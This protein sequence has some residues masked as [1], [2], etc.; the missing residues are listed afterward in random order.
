MKMIEKNTND[1]VDVV[2]SGLGPTGLVLAHILGQRGHQV[3]VLEREPIFYGNARAVY[4][5]DEC[6]RIF[7]SIGMADELHKDMLVDT[8]VQLARPDGKVM[9]QYKPLQRPNGW[10]IVNFF[11]QP[12]LETSLTK[13]LEKYPNVDIRRGRELVNFS[14]T[15]DFVTIEHQATQQYRFNDSTNLK[16]EGDGNLDLQKIQALYLI[17]ADGGRSTVRAK[18]GIEMTGKN[19]PEPWLVVDLKQK[20]R[21]KGLRHLP[22]FNFV[23]DPDLPVVSCVQP[24]GFHRFEFM[25]KKGQTA[26]YMQR[27]ETVREL[28]SKFVNPDDFEVKRKLVYTFN[29]LVANQWRDRRI[30]LA[31]DAAHMTPQFMGQ[32]ASSGIRDAHNLGWKLSDVLLGRAG[33]S[34]LDTYESE[35]RSHAKAMID[36]S[37][38]LKD[39][40]S[41]TNPITSKFR[42]GVIKTIQSVPLLRK[43]SDEGGFKPSPVYKKDHYLG[44]P[45]AKRYSPEGVLAPQPTVRNFDGKRILLDDVLGDSYSLIGLSCDPTEFL[46]EQSKIFLRHLQAKSVLVHSYAA[47]PQ[48]RIIRDLNPELNE[49]ED[50]EHTFSKWIA[51]TATK[52]DQTIVILR[53]DHFVF[54]LVSPAQ[55]NS[56]LQQ[57]KLQLLEVPTKAAFANDRTEQCA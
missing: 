40:V 36:S 57:L 48:G 19:F 11:Y 56:A 35:R 39:L 26:E 31:G 44:L 24:D 15:Q 41:M 23:V 53:P 28:L 29:A 9:A 34:L 8:P 21:N 52:K 12:Y 10:P 55:L 6:M 7:Q 2:I 22:Y 13:A 25:L 38:F 17:G 47:R 51:K 46:S 27:P 54:A 33:D 16:V 4:T 5:D 42:D 43:W 14:Q 45:R 32:G 1:I 49:V 18:I 30:F 3:V 20:D 50:I 37:V